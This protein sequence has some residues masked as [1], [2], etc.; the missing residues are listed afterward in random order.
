MGF[1]FYNHPSSAPSFSAEDLA[2]TR[3]L[4]EA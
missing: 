3:R 1:F 2:S 4:A